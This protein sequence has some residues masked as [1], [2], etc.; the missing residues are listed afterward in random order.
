MAIFARSR[1]RDEERQSGIRVGHGDDKL[2][3]PHAAG[4]IDPADG[5]AD[6]P[7]KLAQHIVAR[8]V[9]ISVVDRLEV[10]DVEDQHRQR[11]LP[12]DRLLHQRGEVALKIAA[13]VE[14]G[15]PVGDRHLDGHL[16]VVAQPIGEA[17]AADLGAHPR[18]HLVPIDRPDEVVVHAKIET[19]KQTH[20]VVRVDDDEDRQLPG[21]VQR[22]EMRAQPQAVDLLEIEADDGEVVVALSGAEERLLRFGLVIDGMLSATACS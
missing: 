3:A 5:L 15:E 11:L 17:L 8:R 1:S 4:K 6:P 19:A 2:L 10:V 21:A 18:Q 9:A 12:R 7:G 16:H 20:V 13:I 14:T 22:A